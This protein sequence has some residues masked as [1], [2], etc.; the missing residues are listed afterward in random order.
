MN[1]L[2]TYSDAFV[3]CLVK[4]GEDHP[5]TR[6]YEALYAEARIVVG[7]DKPTGTSQAGGAL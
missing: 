3:M 2:R 6:K 4:Y 1:A 5:E 7:L